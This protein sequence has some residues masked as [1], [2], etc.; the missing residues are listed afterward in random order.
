[1]KTEPKKRGLA[2]LTADEKAKIVQAWASGG[3]NSCTKLCEVFNVTISCVNRVI[4]NHIKN[5]RNG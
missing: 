1:M 2:D 3:D 4:D 5:L